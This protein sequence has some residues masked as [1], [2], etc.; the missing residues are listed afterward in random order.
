MT[1]HICNYKLPSGNRQQKRNS[2]ITC[3]LNEVAGNG[4]GDKASHYQYN[5]ESYDIY[6]I[7]LK[8]P[9]RLNKGFDFTVNID[10]LY[11]KDRKKYSNPRHEDIFNALSYCKTHY[12]IEYNNISEAIISIYNC[13][14]IDLS[15]INAYFLDFEGSKHPIQIIILA[16]KW[17]FMEQDCA[18]WNYSGRYMLF[19]KL[20]ELNL[21]DN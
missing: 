16:L 11:F 9:T 6:R 12:P 3:F 2:I 10:G 1:I 20:N 15:H 14:D 18:Y 13:Y 4:T 8:R 7:Y 21:I 5:V 19:N 17:L